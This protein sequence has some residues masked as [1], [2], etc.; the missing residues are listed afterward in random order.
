[1]RPLSLSP[2]MLAHDAMALAQVIKRTSKKP[3]EASDLGAITRAIKRAIADEKRTN[4]KEFVTLMNRAL[5]LASVDPFDSETRD[6]F[7]RYLRAGI[8]LLV[9]LQA[10]RQSAS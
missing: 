9:H 4:T 7:H 2:H 1:M 6:R 5:S 3:P 10:R 8:G